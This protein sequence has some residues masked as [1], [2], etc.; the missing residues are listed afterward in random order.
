MVRVKRGTQAQ[1]RK[2]K[3]IKQAKGFKWTRKKCFRAAKQ[4][5]MKAW[6]Y[7]YR[8]RKVRKREKRKLWQ[9]QISA[10]SKEKGISYSKFIGKLKKENIDINR[11]ILAELANKKPEIFNEILNTLN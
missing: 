2:K 8:D 5:L 9:T 7:S 4:A 1:K 3:T 10:L 6:S 11:K